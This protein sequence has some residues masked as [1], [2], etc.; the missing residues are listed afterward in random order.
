MLGGI[1]VFRALG[2]TSTIVHPQINKL[3]A[4]F[5]A[6]YVRGEAFMFKFHQLSGI[7]DFLTESILFGVYT[8]NVALGLYLP[9]YA[10]DVLVINDVLLW[11]NQIT[12]FERDR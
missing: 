2:I 9:R 7:P 6:V 5:I 4:C 12:T 1:R 8:S 10:Y 3:G 11:S